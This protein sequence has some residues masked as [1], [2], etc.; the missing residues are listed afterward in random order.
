M[1][2]LAANNTFVIAGIVFITIA[3]IGQS[4]LGFIEINPGCFGRFLALIIGISSLLYALGLLNFSV[5]N[6]DSLK[7]YLL[8][9]IQ[10][11]FN[12]INELLQGS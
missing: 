1:T 12:S 6:I 11:S 3:V 2:D 10:Q 4:K 9:L 8:E 7:N 5:A